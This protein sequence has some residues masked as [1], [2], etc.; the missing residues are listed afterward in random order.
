MN[1]NIQNIAARSRRR[2]YT[3]WILKGAI[4]NPDCIIVAHNIKYANTLQSRYFELLD[5]EPFYKKWYWK[6]FGRKHP[7]FLSINSNFDGYHQPIIYDNGC[8]M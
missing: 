8:F 4:T 6:W 3:Q 7:K 5:K 1:N 2:G